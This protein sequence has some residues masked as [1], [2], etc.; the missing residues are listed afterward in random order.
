[1]VSEW[2]NVRELA[3]WDI[4]PF[5]FLDKTFC[6]KQ[7]LG[8]GK[9]WG[10]HMHRYGRLSHQPGNALEGASDPEQT[11]FGLHSLL[12][13]DLVFCLFLGHTQQYL[14]LPPALL[15]KCT[16]LV[17]WRNMK[18]RGLNLGLPTY[19]PCTQGQSHSIVG[20][21]LALHAANSAQLGS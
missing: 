21:V 18:C 19:K 10:P 14:G 20:S 2:L 6:S 16:S 8:A 5:V 4:F 9:H 12:H 3:G 7:A 13:M 15:S 17:I 11:Q 1:M